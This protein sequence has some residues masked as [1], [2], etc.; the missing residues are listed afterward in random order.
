MRR[1]LLLPLLLLLFA[2]CGPRSEPFGTGWTPPVLATPQIAALENQM[3]DRVNRDRAA[4]GLGALQWDARL[5]DIGRA[6]SLD[7]RQHGF[8]AHQSPFTGTLEDRMNRAGYL[9]LEM[10]ENLASATDIHKA[11]ENLLVSPGHYE[12]LMAT[13]VTHLGIGIM[14]GSP[15][16]D[17]RLMTITQVFARPTHL[18]SPDKAVHDITAAIQAARAQRRLPALT[19]HPLLEQIARDQVVTLPDDLPG[20]AIDR[21]SDAMGH[22]LN[23]VKGH[24]LRS[25]Q[26]SAQVVFNATLFDLTATALDPR[27]RAIGMAAAPARDEKGRPR[28][29]VLTIFGH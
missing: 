6:H 1:L 15:S 9:A 14:P 20:H 24:G 29:K 8:F 13:G 19:Q 7:M 25:M 11:E 4:R 28:V 12:N 23:N 21:V 5:A 3:W 10:R 27:T 17:P 16:G 22:A 26:L 18:D 2:G